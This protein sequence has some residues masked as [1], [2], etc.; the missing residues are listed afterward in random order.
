MP[1]LA[2][3]IKYIIINL[4]KES[5]N[6]FPPRPIP[7]GICFQGK[8]THVSHKVKNQVK[9]IWC[10]KLLHMDLVEP[11]QSGKMY[12]FVIVD[13]YSGY[14]WVLFLTHKSGAFE[15]FKKLINKI[16]IEKN[17]PHYGH[18]QW[19][20]WGIHQWKLCGV[21]W[22]EKDQALTLDTKDPSTKWGSWKTKYITCGNDYNSPQWSKVPHKFWA[23]A[24][25]T[26][27][28]VCNKCLVRHFLGKTSYELYNG[29]IPTIS[30]FK[31]F[32]SRCYI[33]YTK[34][35][36]NLIWKSK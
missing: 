36:V 32:S 13:D 29:K 26:A 25:D 11:M 17:A 24:I 15:V 21:F 20:R 30:H 5:S 19:S 33:C 3:S 7:C 31:V 34:I 27:C 2:L 1:E 10:L 22:Q 6:Y 28:Y 9:T 12:I 35:K 16:T 14:I 4:W 8:Q 18:K 23:E